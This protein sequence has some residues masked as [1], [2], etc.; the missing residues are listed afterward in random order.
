MT[1][2]IACL[3]AD[4]QAHLKRLINEGQW[5][6]VYLISSIPLSFAAE[7]EVH[8]LIIDSS[9]PAQEYIAELVSKLQG[10][11]KGFEVALNIVSGA[12]KEHVG[13]LAACLK[14]G[15]GIRLVAVT[16]E[17]ISELS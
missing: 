15:F 14:L 9:Q 4:H 3:A 5:E 8:A 12:G 7:K 16:R 2:L 6:Q 17:G 13:I 1:S 10:K 11:I